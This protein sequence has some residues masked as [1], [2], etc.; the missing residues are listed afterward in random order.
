[1]TEHGIEV[2]DLGTIPYRDA[3]ALQLDLFGRLLDSTRAGDPAPQGTLLLVEHPHV[4]TLGRHGHA[5]NLLVGADRLAARGIECVRI[6]RGGD[7]TYHG[8]GQLVAYPLISMRRYGLGVKSYIALLEEAVI[9]TLLTYGITAG[10]VEDAT[11]VWIGI[12]TPRERKICAIGVKCSRFCTMHG[13]ALNVNTDLSYFHAINPCGFTDKGVTSI[14]AELG[15]PVDMQELKHR[16]T[17]IFLS[18]LKP[19]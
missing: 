16:F 9:R 12:G 10:R 14:A 13:L 3:Y 4:Y 5:D 1:M 7:I 8:P 6:E 18:L 11:G 19:D 2:R 17:D 15:H